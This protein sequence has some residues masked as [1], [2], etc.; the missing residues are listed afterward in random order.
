MLNRE[1]IRKILEAHTKVI[2]R[3]KDAGKDEGI[4]QRDVCDL[5]LGEL[6]EEKI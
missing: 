5:V 3:L 1:D 6:S 4:S 2:N